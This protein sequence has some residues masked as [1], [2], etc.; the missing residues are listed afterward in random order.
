MNGD[1]SSPATTFPERLTPEVAVW[2]LNSHSR[3]PASFLA[4]LAQAHPRLDRGLVT[5][6][7]AH[8]ETKGILGSHS[9]A[10]E[11]ALHREVIERAPLGLHLLALINE[12]SRD[13]PEA[14]RLYRKLEEAGGGEQGHI[15]LDLARLL[16]AQGGK[17]EACGLLRR[18]IQGSRDFAFLTRAAKQLMRLKDVA[19]HGCSRTLKLA[20][21]HPYTT[22][23]L[24]PLLRL[25]LFREGIWADI[26]TPP[27]GAYRQAI[28]DPGSPFYAFGPEMVILLPTW[29]ELDLPFLVAEPNLRAQELAAETVEVWRTILARVP[30]RI[31]QA[32][33]EIP[34][35]DAA[36]H[37]SH[38][39]PG[40]RA[41]VIRNLNERILEEARTHHVSV[42]NLD[43]LAASYGKR[44]W[45][46]ASYWHLAKQYPAPNGLPTFVDGIVARIRAGLG[47]TKKVLVLDLDNTLWGGVIG[48]EGL[49]GIQVGPPSAT[50]EAH[51]AFQ[52]YAAQLKERG[53]LLGVCSK[54]NEADAKAPFLQHEAMHLK[55][56]DFAAFFANWQ[57]KPANLRAMA[58]SLNLGLDSFVFVD[59]NPTERA[60]VR[61]ELPEVSVP[62]IGSDPACYVEIL[63][64]TGY[65]DADSLSSEDL[66]R[67][68]N[69]LKNLEREAF[70]SDQGSLD[71]FLAGLA[72]T[73]E[74]GPFDEHWLPRIVQLIGK[75]NQFNLTTRRHSEAHVRQMMVDP[76][77]WTH[78]FRLKDKFDDNGLVG[79]MIATPHPKE[80]SVWELDTW[81][82]SCRVIGRQLEQ[83][84]FNA[85]LGAARE[86]GITRIDG[87]FLPT[88]KNAMVANLFTDMGFSGTPLQG[89]EGVV[90]RIEPLTLN[91]PAVRFIQ[92]ISQ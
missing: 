70:R 30:V 49:K 85:L 87:L 76:A 86:R 32:N 66:E 31:I 19:A 48:E 23:L 74:H 60:F 56:E 63:D 79:I 39:L 44:A 27:Y 47:L 9:F 21:L 88:A 68:R 28:L 81:L 18:A 53:I 72:M 20:V 36:G 7:I 11:L 51:L 33:F 89:K 64:G 10:K 5:A 75:T 6:I 92:D 12:M 40:G 41:S 71:S 2:M 59:D 58:R 69:Y 67:S 83:F 45:S 84:M 1:P 90:Y 54:N 43:H 77:G 61:Q 82:M 4:E 13:L 26:F 8:L 38:I 78:Y 52:R 17:A 34:A 73:C 16:A 3:G 25:G 37:L 91:P 62:E 55:L 22:D 46:D 57:D 24:V 29:R 80:D 35:I 14:T 50:G 15:L 65:F 42:L